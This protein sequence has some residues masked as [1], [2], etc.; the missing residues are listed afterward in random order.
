MGLE[1]SP[2]SFPLGISFFTFTQIAFLVDCYRRSA[3][4]DNPVF[5]SL[6]VTFFPYLL[7]GPIVRHGEVMSQFKEKMF[8]ARDY[9]HISAGLYLLFIG[10]FKKVA[11]ADRFSEWATAG[12][13]GPGPLNFFYAWAASLSYTFQ[14]YFDFS[15]Y[16]DM[17]LG[18]ALMFH[19][20]L[21]IN[22]NSPY[23]ALDVQDFWRR[24]HMSLSRF[25]RDYVYFPLGGSR[26]GEAR[27]YVNL[28]VVFLICGLWHGAGWTFIFWGFLYGTAAVVQRF[29]N[30]RGGTLPDFLAWFLTFNF[31]NVA[32]VFFR[33][34]TWED[35]L[36]VLSG[37]FGLNGM[38]LPDSWR[39]VLGSLQGDYFQFLPWKEIMQGSRDAYV[40][41]PLALCLCLFFKNSNQMAERFKADWKSL[42]W[43]AAGAY[44]VLNMVKK[45]DFIYLNF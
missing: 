5:Y 23:K 6:L 27:I 4:E 42:I 43:V 19:I 18:A 9:R 12:F 40:F 34:Q 21:P 37:M 14:I 35:A 3:R 39:P 45:T 7:S 11:L 15:G 1:V 20:K 30:K 33:A 24:W 32:W 8:Q 22:F 26:V 25:L 31:I 38:A 29:W 28:L 36:K 16:T 2:G 13:D 44:A 17:A 10:L 41:I